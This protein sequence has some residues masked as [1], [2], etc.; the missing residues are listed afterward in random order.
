MK[1][2]IILWSLIN[3]LILASTAFSEE[4]NMCEDLGV[5]PTQ[6]REEL[7]SRM[8][9]A[10]ENL[11]KKIVHETY[12]KG[13]MSGYLGN[14]AD[15]IDQDAKKQAELLF[16]KYGRTFLSKEMCPFEHK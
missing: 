15:M 2:A 4:L 1:R 14:T 7:I 6:S 10:K 5:C 8:L 9:T 13:A 16:E 3:I 11:F 12:L